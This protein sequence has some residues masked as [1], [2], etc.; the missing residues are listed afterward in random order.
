L[1]AKFDS[2]VDPI[3]SEIDVSGPD[4]FVK[5]TTKARLIYIREFG[6]AIA[7]RPRGLYKDW[8]FMNFVSP[9]M[10]NAAKMKA[11]SSGEGPVPTVDVNEVHALPQPTVV[12]LPVPAPP[13]G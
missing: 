4:S 9:D 10:V 2:E 6:Y 7:H 5:E 11:V 8:N 1:F 3:G 12:P 13:R